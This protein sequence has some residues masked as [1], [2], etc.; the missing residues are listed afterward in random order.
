MMSNSRFYFVSLR[1][2]SAS[3][4]IN[5]QKVPKRLITSPT[6][7]HAQILESFLL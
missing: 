7:S 4:A 2:S 6:M 3:V 1:A 5:G